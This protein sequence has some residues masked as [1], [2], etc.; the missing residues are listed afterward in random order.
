MQDRF[1]RVADEIGIEPFGRVAHQLDGDL[2][3]GARDVLALG[4]PKYQ[5]I[6]P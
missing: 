1:R 3:R 5:A 4:G 6:W 2:V